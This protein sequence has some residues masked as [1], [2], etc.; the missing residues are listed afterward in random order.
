[1]AL[2]D[3]EM[4]IAAFFKASRLDFPT[5]ASGKLGLKTFKPARRTAGQA[6]E[7]E[8]QWKQ[9]TAAG[10]Q[11]QTSSKGRRCLRVSAELFSVR[12][13]RRMGLVPGQ[14]EPAL[15]DLEDL[16]R[17]PGAMLGEG[18]SVFAELPAHRKIELMEALNMGSN[19]R[20][21]LDLS[22]RHPQILVL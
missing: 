18:E 19:S 22:A 17:S 21:R 16:Q 10:A 15:E 20:T 9:M 12:Q 5:E 4:L 7:A 11:L 14:E 1:M 13:G 2:A 6:V 8:R 3:F